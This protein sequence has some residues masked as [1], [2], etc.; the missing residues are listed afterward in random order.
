MDIVL[1]CGSRGT[2][3]DTLCQRLI[4]GNVV[5]PMLW[6]RKE[7]EKKPIPQIEKG[8]RVAFAY[9]LKKQLWASLGLPQGFDDK[10]AIMKDGRTFRAHCV[11]L[12]LGMREK[13]PTYWC[14]TALA[15]VENGT[16]TI[17]T[18]WRFKNE[19]EYATSIGKVQSIRV[20]RREIPVPP[21]TAVEEH[22]LDGDSTDWLVVNSVEDYTVVCMYMPQYIEYICS[23]YVPL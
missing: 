19:Y 2:G 1:I 6:Y 23:I 10:D 4:T 7:K 18:D 17:V 13:D 3:K 16:T 11:E 15:C 20:F 12:G 21:Q 5:Y 9:S 14:R 22:A 8:V